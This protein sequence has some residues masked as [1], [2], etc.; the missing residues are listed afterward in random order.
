LTL[1]FAL[2]PPNLAKIGAI[3]IWGWAIASAGALA[4]A[5]VYARLG[6]T[7]PQAPVPVFRTL[8]KYNKVNYL[9]GLAKRFLIQKP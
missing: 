6:T 9:Q 2:L 3:S 5:N 1:E 8:Q 7:D 4:L